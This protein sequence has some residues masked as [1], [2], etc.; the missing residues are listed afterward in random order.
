[1]GGKKSRKARR[2][3]HCA[4]KTQKAQKTEHLRE[5]RRQRTR[6]RGNGARKRGGRSRKEVVEQGKEGKKP[7]NVSRETASGTPPCAAGGCK[8]GVSSGLG[9]LLPARMCPEALSSKCPRESAFAKAPSRKRLRGS[10]FAVQRDSTTA[11]RSYSKNTAHL[12]LG[13]AKTVF[14][15]Q[16]RVQRAKRGEK[17]PRSL[18]C[19]FGPMPSNA[20]F[21]RRSSPAPPFRPAL[22]HVEHRF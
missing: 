14:D 4:K 22:F 18:I 21:F 13:R 1:M 8:I 10:A 11:S 9:R 5:K 12:R 6:K 7:Q 15:G 3:E 16:E 20:S 17:S 19:P 2:N